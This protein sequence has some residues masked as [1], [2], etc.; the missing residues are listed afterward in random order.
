MEIVDERIMRFINCDCILLFWFKV[1]VDLFYFCNLLFVVLMYKKMIRWG[2][3]IFLG[4][5]FIYNWVD[6]LNGGGNV[7]GGGGMM[8][9]VVFLEFCML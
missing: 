4:V 5:N 8:G 2:G 7:V 1:W 3:F 6:V 9:I